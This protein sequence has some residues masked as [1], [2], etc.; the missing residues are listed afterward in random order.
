MIE[1]FPQPLNSNRFFELTSKGLTRAVGQTSKA[2]RVY[3]T[4]FMF[5]LYSRYLHSGLAGALGEV[6]L[7]SQ[8]SIRRIKSRPYNYGKTKSKWTTLATDGSK[9]EWPGKNKKPVE[10]TSITYTLNPSGGV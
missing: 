7:V 8:S 10:I 5:D 3:S 2:R 9:I 1:F 4:P 6:G